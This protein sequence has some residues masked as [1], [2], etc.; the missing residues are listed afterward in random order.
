MG[1]FR[2]GRGLIMLERTDHQQV[3]YIMAKGSY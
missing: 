1:G 2:A 3:R